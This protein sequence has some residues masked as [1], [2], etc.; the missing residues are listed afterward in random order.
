MSPR[1]LPESGALIGRVRAVARSNRGIARGAW[2]AARVAATAVAAVLLLFHGWLLWHQLGSG[3]LLDPLTATKW[4]AALAMVGGLVALKAAGV[5]LF[6]GRQ[7]LV[8]WTLV[9]IVHWSAAGRVAEVTTPENGPA[10][11]VTVALPAAEALTGLALALAALNPRAFT[12]TYV[13]LAL[14][15]AVP[16]ARTLAGCRLDAPCRAPPLTA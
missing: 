11:A 7:A 16:N 4:A 9:V 3:E 6:K 12:P 8:M 14:V 13:R 2:L 10:T 1:L 15:G 5:S